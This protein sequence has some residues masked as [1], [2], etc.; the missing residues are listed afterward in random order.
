MAVK[1]YYDRNTAPLTFHNFVRYASLPWTFLVNLAE[2]FLLSQTM[3]HRSQIYQF[4]ML[5][6]VAMLILI[7]VCFWGF[8]KWKPCGWYA[9]MAMLALNVVF[10]LLSIQFYATYAPNEPNSAG[11]GL[12]VALIRGT[13]VGIYYYKR[14]PLFFED[15]Q[16][17]EQ[18]MVAEDPADRVSAAR[19]CRRCGATLLPGSEFCN[20]C[21]TRV[22]HLEEDD[23][24]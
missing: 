22:I 3:Y 2:M 17:P 11:P 18:E 7:G 19:F 1:M 20:H 13:L 10:S 6:Y 15:M 8:L 16:S 14:K 12:F 4:S 23:R 24:P 9:I 21:G 5:L